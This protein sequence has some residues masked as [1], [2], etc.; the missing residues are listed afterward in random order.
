MNAPT[1]QNGAVWMLSLPTSLV[2]VDFN[3]DGLLDLAA[4]HRHSEDVTIMT[5][6]G[7]GTFLSFQSIELESGPR[8]LIAG[9]VPPNSAS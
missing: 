5:G 2:P 1:G 4:T 3:G 8:D 6:L 7:D 9:T